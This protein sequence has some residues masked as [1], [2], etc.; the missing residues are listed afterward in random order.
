MKSQ[1]GITM[2]SLIIYV[3]AML[4]IVTVLTII[5]GYIYEGIGANSASEDFDAKYV[6][7]LAYISKETNIKNNKVLSISKKNTG[8]DNEQTAIIFE[9]GKQLTY[10]PKNRSVY[11]EKIKICDNIDNFNVNIEEDIKQKLNI[12]LIQETK[13]A[14]NYFIF[15]I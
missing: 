7:L 8:M 1:K 2:T 15:N 12:E 9:S 13:Q 11:Y 10:I 3:F 6:R 4:L 14:N 5:T